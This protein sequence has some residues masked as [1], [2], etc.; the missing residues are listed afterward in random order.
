MNEKNITSNSIKAI[1]MAITSPKEA[2][3]I[4]KLT[5]RED[6]K[7]FNL[8]VNYGD[9]VLKGIIA[10]NCFRIDLKEGIFPILSSEASGFMGF[11]FLQ[12]GDNVLITVEMKNTEDD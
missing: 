11:D 7:S 12:N 10:L 8:E 1:Y 4:L 2:L 3:D 9:Y 6:G 5:K